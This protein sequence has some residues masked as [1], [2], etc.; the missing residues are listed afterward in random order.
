MPNLSVGDMSQS[1]MLRQQNTRLSSELGRLTEELA[2]GR[3]ADPSRHLKGNF[4]HL[5]ALE[6]D[7]AILESYGMA[8]TEAQTFTDTMQTALGKVQETS[9]NLAADL[10]AAGDGGLPEVVQSASGKAGE[11]FDALVTTLNSSVAGQALFAGART[12]A[13]ALAS[14]DAML[15]EIRGEVSG[16]TDLPGMI[17]AVEAWFNTPGG[18]FETV[19]YLGEQNGTKPFLLGEN[20]TVSLNLGADAPQLRNIL[21]HTA[22]AALAADPDLGLPNE[23]QKSLLA[24]AGNGLVAAQD[25]LTGI[26][27]DLGYT[28][29][30]VEEI[31]TRIASEKTASEY[32]INTL[33]GVDPFE[34]VT[35][36]EEV[37]LQL[38]S[39]YTAT[40]RLGRLSLAEY[41]R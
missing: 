5:S 7:R 28:E 30:R 26:R 32:A 37:Q 19:G 36:L 27:A 12:D 2:T 18:G 39:L 41:M 3:T 4:S 1:V 15:T 23:L 25:P 29:A 38:E 40:V 17:A 31:A 8:A 11:A 6:R 14:A 13:T 16:E 20:E 21:M 9:G 35:R 34:T 24:H 22:I 33:L 10:L